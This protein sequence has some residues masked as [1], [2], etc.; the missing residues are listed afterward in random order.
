MI[1]INSLKFSP[2]NIFVVLGLFFGLLFIFITPPFQVPDEFAHFCR[3]FQVSEGQIIVKYEGEQPGDYIPISLRK[4]E[5]SLIKHIPF[6]PEN[7]ITLNEIVLQSRVPLMPKQRSFTYCSAAMYSPIPYFPQIIGW[8]I[9]RSLSLPIL[10][11][12]YTGRI[13]NLLAWI[14]FTFLAIRRAP[15]FRWVFLLIALMPMSLFLAASLSAD[16]MTNALSFLFIAYILYLAFD[17]PENI[18]PADLAILCILTISSTLTK[19]PNILLLGIYFLIPVRKLGSIKHYIAAFIFLVLINSIIGAIWLYIGSRGI[20]PFYDGA[21]FSEQVIFIINNPV[22]YLIAI[23]RTIKIHRLLFS[24]M[25][26]GFLGWLDTVLPY[27]TYITYPVILVFMALYENTQR[28]RFNLTNRIIILVTLLSTVLVV[29]TFLYLLSTPVGY[30]TIL[31][32]QGRYLITVAPLFFLLFY[33]NKLAT[34]L[35]IK[36]IV[37]IYISIVLLTTLYTL[38]HRYYLL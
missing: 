22:N 3:A 11:I 5:V 26:V 2:E 33:N 9:G 34:N 19:P 30:N 13:F 32:F 7:K 21:D 1:K 8:W 4:L 25:F 17:H 31:G 23:L 37:P 24:G 28:I 35:P 20:I 10:A 6:H 36:I 12:F 29:F 38:V 14:V 15:V 16:A 18:S 27:W